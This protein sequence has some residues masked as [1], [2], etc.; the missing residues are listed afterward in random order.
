[1]LV[2]LVTALCNMTAGDGFSLAVRACWRTLDAVDVD[3]AAV[4][5]ANRPLLIVTFIGQDKM[6][7]RYQTLNNKRFVDKKKRHSPPRIAGAEA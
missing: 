2:R 6:T 4:R 7:T 5:M 3:C 1:M